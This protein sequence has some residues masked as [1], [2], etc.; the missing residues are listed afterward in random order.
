MQLFK[1]KNKEESNTN[2]GLIVLICPHCRKEHKVQYHQVKEYYLDGTPKDLEGA[3]SMSVICDCGCVCQESYIFDCQQWSELISQPEHQVILS[4]NYG[5]VERKIRI[6]LLYP[7]VYGVR[8]VWLTHVGS[9]KE[10]HDAL[11]S[12]IPRIESLSPCVVDTDVLGCYLPQFK[13]KWPFL[14]T[15]DMKLA[16][17]Y[18]RVGD[19]DKA[20]NLLRHI[21]HN[22]NDKY[23]QEYVALQRMLIDQQNQGQ[24]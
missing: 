15:K 4:G 21:A 16:D 11:L 12:A 8:D 24:I 22:A 7:G 18:R 17:M 1:R 9:N 20:S 10:N 23:T 14:I 2:A 5:D 13:W 19:F 3:L 6:M